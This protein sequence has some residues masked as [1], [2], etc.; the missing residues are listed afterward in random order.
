MGELAKPS[1]CS[2]TPQCAH[3]LGLLP[4]MPVGI[5]SLEGG[6][7]SPSVVSTDFWLQ[8]S[9]LHLFNRR[10]TNSSCVQNTTLEMSQSSCNDSPIDTLL[11]QRIYTLVDEE[12]SSSNLPYPPPPGP[13]LLRKYNTGWNI[14]VENFSCQNNHYGDKA[15]LE[16]MFPQ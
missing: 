4:R 13:W 15:T 14:C 6:S 7:S 12:L 5:T 11:W 2:S 1:V 3:P 10:H 16:A 8:V 9:E